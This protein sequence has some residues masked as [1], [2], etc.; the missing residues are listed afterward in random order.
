MRSFLPSC[1]RRPHEG[2]ILKALHVVMQTLSSPRTC[3]PQPSTAPSMHKH[4]LG[5]QEVRFNSAM[6]VDNADIILKQISQ[7]CRFCRILIRIP[8]SFCFPFAEALADAIDRTLTSVLSAEWNSFVFFPILALGV[9]ISPNTAGSSLSS[10]ICPNLQH[11]TRSP[12]NPDNLCQHLPCHQARREMS[13]SDNLRSHIN[14]KLMHRRTTT[15]AS[16]GSCSR[17]FG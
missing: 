11:L 12:S 2:R 4:L 13:S 7:L 8:K 15:C 3:H 5:Q 1:L 14:M 10:I 6:C 9:P 17:F 16:L